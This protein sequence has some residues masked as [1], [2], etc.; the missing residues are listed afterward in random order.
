M[1]NNNALNNSNVS[2]LTKH[3]NMV[4]FGIIVVFLIIMGIVVSIKMMDLFLQVKKI[5]VII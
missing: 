1:K 4:V 5:I 3:K 2:F